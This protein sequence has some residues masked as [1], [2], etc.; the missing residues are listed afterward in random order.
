[1]MQK[2]FLGYNCYC[3]VNCINERM[4]LQFTYEIYLQCI[5]LGV[6]AVKVL[7]SHVGEVYVDMMF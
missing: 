7:L 2:R 6:H 3:C 4:L 1:M 5:V